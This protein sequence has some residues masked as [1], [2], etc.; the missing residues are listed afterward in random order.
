MEVYTR[1]GTTNTI[2]LRI[3]KF[4]TTSLNP[5]S[6]FIRAGIYLELLLPV[7][8]NTFTVQA[9]QLKLIYDEKICAIIRNFLTSSAKLAITICPDLSE[10]LRHWAESSL[11]TIGTIQ[12]HSF[13]VFNGTIH[14][15][16]CEAHRLV[17]PKILESWATVFDDSGKAFG[18]FATYSLHCK[19]QY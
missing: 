9:R 5:N 13:N 15:A 14:D 3:C 17:A 1:L 12:K 8:T 7:W 18:K 11:R 16:A 4:F 10:P 2:G 6:H 19:I